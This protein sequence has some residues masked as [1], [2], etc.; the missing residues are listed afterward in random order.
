MALQ[1]ERPIRAQGLCAQHVGTHSE[2]GGNPSAFLSK[3]SSGGTIARRFLRS[4][5]E[6][7]SRCL[8]LEPTVIAT[9][10]SAPSTEVTH[11]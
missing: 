1:A 2:S 10:T 7:G 11:G 8:L 4:K 3:A 5:S 9:R 6:G